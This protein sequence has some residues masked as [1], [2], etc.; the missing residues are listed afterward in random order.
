LIVIDASATIA[1]ILNEDAA[2]TSEQT[3]RRLVADDVVVPNHWIA[4]IGNALVSN[5]RRGRL[6]RRQFEFVTTTLEQLEIN[7]EPPPTFS[8]LI[9][10]AEGAI[11]SG[12]TYYDAAYVDKARSYQAPLFTFDRKMRA[13]ASRLSIPLLP[14]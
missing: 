2:A 5:V 13:A 6:D 3:F 9:A 4:E 14:A 7:V 1:L 11:D 8:E 12:L 10:I